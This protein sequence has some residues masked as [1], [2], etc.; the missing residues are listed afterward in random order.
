MVVFELVQVVLSQLPSLENITWLSVL[1]ATM[2]F[3]Y[4]A[5]RLGLCVAKWASYGD[6]RG[7]LAG[8]SE[9]ALSKFD[10]ARNVLLALGNIAFAYT[11]ADVLIEIQVKLLSFRKIPVGKMYKKK[12]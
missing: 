10:K 3:T 9:P 2:S 8:V 1:A 11:S 7:G 4:S 6:L 12:H 5:I